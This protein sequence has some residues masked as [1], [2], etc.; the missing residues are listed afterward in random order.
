M[1]NGAFNTTITI[2][3]ITL[4]D[5]LI[6]TTIH[7]TMDNII[8][9]FTLFVDTIKIMDMIDRINIIVIQKYGDVCYDGGGCDTC[10]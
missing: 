10:H 7:N 4:I 2:N 3:T 5:N 1:I 6:D 8:D 9:T